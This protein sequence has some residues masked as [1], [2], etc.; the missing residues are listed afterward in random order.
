MSDAGPAFNA[1]L[2]YLD[3]LLQHGRFYTPRT[4]PMT[5][6]AGK[7]GKCYMNAQSLGM[8]LP[9]LTYVEGRALDIAIHDHGWCVDSEGGVID[10]T[11]TGRRGRS[12]GKAYYGVPLAESYFVQLI[13]ATGWHD[14]VLTDHVFRTGICS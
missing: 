12:H 3:V 10:P 7:M 11:W 1:R 2:R 6:R 13:E 4:L 5:Y 14:R 9:D 8:N